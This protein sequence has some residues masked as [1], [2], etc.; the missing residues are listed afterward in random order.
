MDSNHRPP[1]CQGDAVSFHSLVNLGSTEST[2]CLALARMRYRAEVPTSGGV[3][4]LAKSNTAPD[5]A[6]DLVNYRIKHPAFP[7]EETTDQFF[8]EA[9]WE[10][11]L[12]PPEG[13]PVRHQYRTH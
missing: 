13:L 12:L 2:A 11:Y 10:S 1:P 4:V 8:S 7:V 6:P 5:L 9:Q 3:L